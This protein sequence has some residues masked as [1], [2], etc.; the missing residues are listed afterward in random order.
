MKLRLTSRRKPFEILK[1]LASAQKKQLAL[2]TENAGVGKP[3]DLVDDADWTPM[4][5]VDIVDATNDKPLYELYVWPGGSGILYV[6]DKTKSVARVV[7]HKLEMDDEDADLRV[8]LGKALASAKPK[9]AESIDITAAPPRAK[10][11]DTQA[12]ADLTKAF[13]RSD[14]RYRLFSE[15]TNAQQALV[16]EVASIEDLP[17]YA[18]VGLGLPPLQSLRRWAGTQPPTLLEKMA[19][20]WP[21]WKWLKAA[22][23]DDLDSAKAIAAVTN[24]LSAAEISD[25]CMLVST[26]AWF[27]EAYDLFGKERNGLRGELVGGPF[28][29]GVIRL[30]GALVDASGDDAA[31]VFAKRVEKAL[32][33]ESRMFIGAIATFALAARARRKGEAFPKEFYGLAAEE[34]DSLPGWKLREGMRDI[35]ELIP[36][37]DRDAFLTEFSPWFGTSTLLSIEKGKERKVPCLLHGW[38]Y[39]DLCPN[40]RVAKGMVDNV[41]K[42]DRDPKPV[43]DAIAMFVKVGPVCIPHL[44]A[45]MKTSRSP[46]LAKA[47][48]ALESTSKPAKKAARG[49][50]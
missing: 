11:N 12:L 13:G 8:A 4:E 5:L 48:A 22:T 30:L 16:R 40:E 26:I 31:L 41:V 19:G 36:A 44:K 42:W 45:A 50:G 21:V 17:F 24:A 20:K 46:V 32:A 34:A 28:A 18:V 23:I 1:T 3:A 25:L 39:A 15:L 7:Q 6:H 38:L 9:L 43:A 2:I 35:I 33:D 27:D 37:N 29:V 49:R 47:L 10:R 14:E